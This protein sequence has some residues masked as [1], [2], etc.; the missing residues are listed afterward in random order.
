MT[1]FDKKLNISDSIKP[2]QKADPK[3]QEKSPL[4]LKKRPW[5]TSKA[6]PYTDRVYARKRLPFKKSEESLFYSKYLSKISSKDFKEARKLM[7]FDQ[8][9]ELSRTEMQQ[10]LEKYFKNPKNTALLKKRY[11]LDVDPSKAI[12]FADKIV[13]LFPANYG[14]YIDQLKIESLNKK[15]YK[16]DKNLERSG[17]Y[18]EF[19]ESEKLRE[20]LSDIVKHK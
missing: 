17:K 16:E 8:K 11:K 14:K 19:Q 6:N 15:L 12:E 20:F 5:E 7:L 2:V 1:L 10:K 3:M 13:K 9:L 4:D 18:K